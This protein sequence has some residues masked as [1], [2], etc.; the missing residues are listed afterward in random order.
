VIVPGT[1]RFGVRVVSEKGFEVSPF[2]VAVSETSPI[3]ELKAVPELSTLM[4]E[5]VKDE[6]VILFAPAVIFH[7]VEDPPVE[8][9]VIEVA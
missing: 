4:E 7:V 8:V 1:D 5:P 9:S 6:T 2:A 3:L